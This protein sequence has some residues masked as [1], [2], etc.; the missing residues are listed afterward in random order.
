M[1]MTIMAYAYP[2]ILQGVVKEQLYRYYSKDETRDLTKKFHKEYRLIVR[3]SP[4]IG[5]NRNSFISSYLMGAYL[6]A[7]Y[8]IT[9]DKLTLGDL[10]LI[11]SMGLNNFEFMK[12]K[13]KKK[14]LLSAGYKNKIEQAGEWCRK[15]SDKYPTNW[16]VEVRHIENPDLTNIVFTKCGL[17]TM[18]K[19][20]GVPEFI[21]SLCATDYI[22]MSFANCKL[23]RPTTLGRGD[24][25]CDFY[26]TKL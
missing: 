15:N 7:V 2:F 8:K 6:I 24:I 20:E 1:K 18:C 12:K 17:C 25:C 19:N 5:G 21:S 22:T 11:I 4:D 13:M 16:Q 23:E 3:R 10:D 9:K 14:D 26:I